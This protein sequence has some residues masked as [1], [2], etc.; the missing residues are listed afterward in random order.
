MHAL[1]AE[2]LPENRMNAAASL[3]KRNSDIP[4]ATNG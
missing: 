1:H 4:K 3:W 2:A